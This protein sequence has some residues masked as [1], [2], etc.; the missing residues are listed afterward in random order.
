M[1]KII[2]SI[3]ELWKMMK[4]D[5]K[6]DRLLAGSISIQEMLIKKYED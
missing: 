1:K 2:I 5:I 3:Y 4:D 6:D